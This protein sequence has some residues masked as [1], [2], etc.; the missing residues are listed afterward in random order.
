MGGLRVAQER[1]E[2]ERG[3]RAEGAAE[4]R[5]SPQPGPLERLASFRFAYVA[6]FCFLVAYVFSV[7][8]VQAI[9]QVHF[10]N[11]VV[12]AAA[13][14]PRDGSVAPAV[15]QRVSE[16]LE[17][18]PWIRIGRVQVRALVLGADG[19]TLLYAPG[20]T[21]PPPAALPPAESLLPALVDV[22]VSVPHNSLLAISILVSYAALLV[23]VLLV[24][25]RRLTRREREALAGVLSNRNALS[26]RAEQIETELASVQSRLAEVEPEKEIFA[27]EISSLQGE[28]AQ[29]RQRLATVEQREQ[30]LRMR[31]EQARDLD[32]E[33]R[34][35]EEL[36]EDA[37][38]DLAAKDTE[39]V[40]LRRQ[41]KRGTKREGR[42]SRDVEHLG[43]RLRTLYKDLEVDDQ[44]LQ[45]LAGLGDE[46]LRLRAEEALKRLCDDPDNAVVRRKLGGLPPHL[47]IFELAFAGKGRLYYTRGQERRVRLLLV[48]A[49]NRQKKDLEYLSRLPKGS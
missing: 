24:H 3:P 44:A 32:E 19:F 26:R 14:D 39:L 28:R 1:P 49:K 36:L 30:S 40:Q 37:S 47:A 29:L 23:V 48:G 8:A 5:G 6:I 13:V 34:A 9:L 25:T 42:A 7:E 4:G 18:S 11:E 45:G 31:S 27:E 2:R 35:L 21:L 43:R 38:R 46:S 20:R 41:T 10:R 22:D 15:Q 33:R 12:A 16:I 17:H